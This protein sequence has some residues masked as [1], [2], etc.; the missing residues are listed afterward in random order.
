M[1]FHGPTG[2]GKNYASQFIA[3]VLFE[4]GHLSKYFHFIHASSKYH[5]KSK[6]NEYREEIAKM[7]EKAVK[8]CPYQLFVFDEIDKVP[9]GIFDSLTSYLNYNPT[10]NGAKFNKAV[11]IF[12][13]NVGSNY[14][15][16][17]TLQQWSNGRERDEI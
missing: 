2:V 8:E 6:V 16:E 1:T 7:V 17:Q 9:D 5:D 15:I 11:F 12:L 14:I 10:V 4:R 3:E 13:T